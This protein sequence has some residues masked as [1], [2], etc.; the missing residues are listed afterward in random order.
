MK[1]NLQLNEKFCH[2]INFLLF[3]RNPI[4]SYKKKCLYQKI[5]KRFFTFWA[6]LENVSD[7]PDSAFKDV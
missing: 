5:Y 3:F 6:R 1:L 2:K 7:H 4:E